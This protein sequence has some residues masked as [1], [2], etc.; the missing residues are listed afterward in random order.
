MTAN[1]GEY[2]D[3]GYMAYS[4]CWRD[5]TCWKLCPKNIFYFLISSIGLFK[6][7]GWL[8]ECTRRDLDNGISSR[9]CLWGELFSLGNRGI[10]LIRVNEKPLNL[11]LPAAIGN[12]P[13]GIPEAPGY[14]WFITAKLQQVQMDSVLIWSLNF[15]KAKIPSALLRGMHS[16]LLDRIV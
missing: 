11:K 13:N 12:L 1:Q 2:W 5:L 6:K 15:N 9:W 3:G 14:L 4:S 8:M 16:W 7:N 10:F